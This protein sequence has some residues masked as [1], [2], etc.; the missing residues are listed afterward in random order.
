MVADGSNALRLAAEEGQAEIAELLLSSY[1]ADINARSGRGAT[2]LLLA[3][4]H[5]HKNVVDVLLNHNAD[6]TIPLQ[7]SSTYHDKFNVKAGDT[8]LHA[9]SKSG[10][11]TIV[12]KLLRKNANIETLNNQNQTPVDVALK[13]SK[14]ANELKLLDYS[15]KTNRRPDNH[16]KRSF[17]IFGHTFTG[18]GCSAKQK[19]DAANALKSVI[20]DG[21]DKSCLDAH[22]EALNNGD[23][24]SIYHSL[25]VR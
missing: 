10:S 7:T 17:T 2:A 24:K 5:G 22:Q 13:D 11:P 18:Y 23:L 1:G 21:A 8:P 19:K 6:I 4:E 16:F 9:A 15:I 14:Y 3:I 20:F 25:K 12:R